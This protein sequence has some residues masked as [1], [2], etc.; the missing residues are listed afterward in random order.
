MKFDGEICGGVLVE[1]VSDDFPQQKKLENLLPN[2]AGSS[3][4]ISPKTLPTSLWK[5]LVLTKLGVPKTN[6]VVCKFCL[7]ALFFALLRPFAQFLCTHLSGVPNANAKSQRF[8]HAISQIATL[9]P[10]VALNRNSILQIAARYAAFWHAISQIALASFFSD[11]QSQR[12]K[13]QCLQDANATKSQMLAFYK[14]QRFS[15]TNPEDPNLNI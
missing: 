8:S 6:L 12:S 3:P 2:F 10:V 13:S 7:E 15:A 5:S 1:N 9:P 14:S 4:P 11:P